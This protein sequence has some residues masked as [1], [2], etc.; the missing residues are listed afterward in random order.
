MTI[1]ASCRRNSCRWKSFT[2][3]TR[4][5]ACSIIC[6]LTSCTIAM[7]SC[8]GSWR[9]ISYQKCI[10]RFT[11]VTIGSTII[12]RT[13]Q[14]GCITCRKTSNCTRIRSCL[15]CSKALA[16]NTNR[17]FCWILICCACQTCIMTSINSYN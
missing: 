10:A 14:T 6:F 5:T 16:I 2:L 9:C 8:A 11:T 7:A 12:Y 1:C 4:Y 3:C 17:A 15:C 13:S